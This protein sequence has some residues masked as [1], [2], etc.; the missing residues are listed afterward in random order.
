MTFDFESEFNPEFDFDWQNIAI[1]VANE[2]LK[3]LEFPFEAQ[4]CLTLVD[5][6]EIKEIN[7]QN[8][9]IDNVTDVLSFPMLNFDDELNYDLLENDESNFDLDSGEAVLG[10]IIICVQRLKNQ[11]AEYGHS[12]LREFAFLVAHSMLHLLGYDHM[13]PEEEKIM[14]KKQDEI[15]EALSITR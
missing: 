6:E 10:D 5:E 14:F 15:L 3:Q 1:A 11:A 2:T 8:R 12:Q 9:G 7:S 4:V 13:E